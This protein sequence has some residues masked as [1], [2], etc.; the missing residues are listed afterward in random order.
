MFDQNVTLSAVAAALGWVTGFAL[1]VLNAIMGLP[2]GHLGL[3]LVAV[4]GVLTVRQ[5]LREDQ[6]R[7]VA[8]FELGQ[9][10]AVH[11]IR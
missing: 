6:R 1:V 5:S 7:N 3:A 2:V 4:G 10:A 11:K 9:E 8:A